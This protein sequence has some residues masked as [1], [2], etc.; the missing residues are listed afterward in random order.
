MST[1]WYAVTYC[2]GRPSMIVDEIRPLGLSSHSDPI[3]T[4]HSDAIREIAVQT[5]TCSALSGGALHCWGTLKALSPLT[6]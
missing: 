6:G 3:T 4:V 2:G 1:A 5:S